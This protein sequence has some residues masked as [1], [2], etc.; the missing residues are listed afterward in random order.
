MT[1]VSTSGQPTEDAPRRPTERELRQLF[2]WLS[3]D[4]VALHAMTPP[5]STARP[6]NE[7]RQSSSAR[8]YGH[9]AEWVSDTCAHIATVLWQWHDAVAEQRNETRP[10]PLRRPMFVDPR[11]L[12]L[13][14][15]RLV[16]RTIHAPQRTVSEQ[17]AI[18]RAWRYL[19]PRMWNLVA[20]T[21]DEPEMFE[22]EF[23]LHRTIRSRMGLG[24][25]QYT[26]PVPC[27][28]DD[29]NLL[30]LQRITYGDR[31]YVECGACG[32]EISAAYYPLLVKMAIDTWSDTPQEDQ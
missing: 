17:D 1:E 26:L 21:V 28:S 25:G 4:W 20:L 30:T 15:R 11:G 14:Q 18:V 29:C 8:E 12:R 5:V 13:V 3:L 16:P 24:R 22:N 27:P 19:E 7:P 9:P 32:Y 31:D 10:R 2:Y 6:S 23:T